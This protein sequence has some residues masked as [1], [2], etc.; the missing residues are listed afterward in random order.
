M[1]YFILS[2][3]IILLTMT[4]FAQEQCSVFVQDALATVN[5][6]CNEVG[7]NEM[8]YGNV[9]VAVTSISGDRIDFEEPGDVISILDIESIRTSAFNEPE[10]WGIVLMN[11]QA[12]VPNTLPGQNVSFLIFGD[13]EL[14]TEVDNDL[15]ESHAPM[16]AI[17]F[18]SGIGQI[19]CNEAPG[20]GILIQT[21][22]IDQPIELII[23]DAEIQLGSTI[24]LQINDVMTIYVLEGH[25]LVT[26]PGLTVFVPQGALT[27]IPLDNN[28]RASNVP[29]IPLPYETA[30]FPSLPLALLPLDIISDNSA[31]FGDSEIDG[32]YTVIIDSHYCPVA[33]PSGIHVILVVGSGYEAEAEALQAYSEDFSSILVDGVAVAPVTRE[34]YGFIGPYW[35]YSTIHE[36][37]TPSPGTYQIS[38]VEQNQTHSCEV[39]IVD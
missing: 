12:N 36:W 31:P 11:I 1:R 32:E 34:Y 4:V 26:I 6:D 15:A 24:Y 38:G 20:A 17:Y 7:R 37:G 39:T 18:T 13:V 30:N 28:G 25:A 19:N 16:Q 23:N 22:N 35:N 21:P 27:R 33:I 14:H 3:L 5:L 2:V 9:H 8:C 29:G 10:E